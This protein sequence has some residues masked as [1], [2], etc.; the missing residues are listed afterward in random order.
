MAE[1][2]R[3]LITG[4]AGQIGAHM[5]RLLHDRYDLRLLYHEQEPPA[6]CGKERLQ[7]DIRDLATME[8]AAAGMDAIVHLAGASRHYHPW[9]LCLELNVIGLYNA[10]EA[11]RRQGVRK[12]VFASSNHAAGNYEL[13]DV[14][15]T[16]ENQARFA[17]E[18]WHDLHPPALHG[19]PVP[20]VTVDLPARPDSYY[21]ATK[22][23]GE[24]LGRYYSEAFGLSVICL[25]IGS[26]LDEPRVPRNLA[27]WC[28]PRDLAQLTWRAIESDIPFLVVYGISGNKRRYWDI[29]PAQRLL[30]YDPED[31]AEEWADRL[32][33]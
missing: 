21:G 6:G 24:A 9:Q 15:M 31:D 25:R 16:P 3:V 7:G 29:A 27:T 17:T 5:S 2:K 18:L 12:V 26:F 8:R 14:P 20:M 23:F 13:D 10:Y 4:A 30:G 32:E 1:R 22:V 28:S 19:A 11:A 33:R